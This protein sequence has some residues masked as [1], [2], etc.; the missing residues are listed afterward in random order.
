MAARGV[1]S[2][3]LSR[4]GISYISR[5]SGRRPIS[6][7]GELQANRVRLNLRVALVKA[8]GGPIRSPIRLSD[9]LDLLFLPRS[10][11]SPIQRSRP[12]FAVDISFSRK[13]A[14]VRRSRRERRIH[15]ASA[16]GRCLNHGGPAVSRQCGLQQHPR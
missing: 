16:A 3:R 2:G 5:V 14:A 12:S 1:E 4:S 9:C 8:F 7:K 10:L 11:S 15:C 6:R 13:I